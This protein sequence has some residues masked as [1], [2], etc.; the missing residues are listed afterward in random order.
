[1]NHTKNLA[2]KDKSNYH[3]NSFNN[4]HAASHHQADKHPLGFSLFYMS[5]SHKSRHRSTA[6]NMTD[7]NAERLAVSLAHAC[8][9]PAS[10]RY[11]YRHDQKRHLIDIGMK[12]A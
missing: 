7:E 2:T 8:A 12:P 5:D 11:R 1:M 9:L 10:S 6:N 4:R 3:W